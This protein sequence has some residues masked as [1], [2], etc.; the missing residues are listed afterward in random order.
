MEKRSEHIDQL[1]IDKLSG[2]ISPADSILL[3]KF[4]K[5]DH[6][7]QEHFEELEKVS[8]YLSGNQFVENINIEQRWEEF[9]TAIAPKVRKIYLKSFW[10]IAA[11]ILLPLLLILGGRYYYQKE[12]NS[13]IS[14]VNRKNDAVQII[15]ADGRKMEITSG[16]KVAVGSLVFDIDSA[17]IKGNHID[18]G[19]QT[20]KLNT[21]QVPSGRDYS[22]TLPDGSRVFMNAASILKFPTDFKGKERVVHLEGEAYFEVAKRPDQPF[23]VYTNQMKIQVTGTKFNVQSYAGEAVQTSLV[24]G[25][26]QISAKNGQIAKLIPGQAARFENKL[27]VNEFDK[28]EVLSWLNGEYYFK[29]TRL[30]DITKMVSRAT[31][32]EFFLKDAI[33]EKKISGAFDK[34]QS[35]QTFLSNIAY[36]SGIKAT[37]SD[38]GIYLSKK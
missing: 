22:I 14:I 25:G 35:I 11:S 33:G 29:E 31:G 23:Y 6:T 37:F 16:K 30:K 7:L 4:L 26:V 21:L 19:Q 18:L 15:M 34:K 24:E 36:S 32:Y 28:D 13:D 8:L 1:I 5:E 27:I 9:E 12:Q 38:K 2:N 3:D 20:E 17:S 10:R